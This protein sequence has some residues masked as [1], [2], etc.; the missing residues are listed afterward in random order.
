MS[1][2]LPSGLPPAHFPLPISF[3]IA[4]RLGRHSS[5]GATGLVASWDHWDSGPIP[6]PCWVRD[7][8]LPLLWLRLHLQLGS[9]SWHW[10]SICHGMAKKGGEKKTG[11]SLLR[12]PLA[13]HIQQDPSSWVVE[14]REKRDREI[15]RRGQVRDGA[16]VTSCHGP[17]LCFRRPRIGRGEVTEKKQFSISLSTACNDI[18]LCLPFLSLKDIL[19]DPL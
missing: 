8:M 13:T 19:A 3:F 15:Q 6:Q 7:L 14:G 11:D 4:K 18:L 17:S 12:L 2:L 16:R 9:D 5:C 1:F 10:T